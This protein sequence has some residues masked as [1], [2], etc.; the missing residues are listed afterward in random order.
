MDKETFNRLSNRH[1]EEFLRQEKIITE[2]SKGLDHVIFVVSTGVFV[3]SINYLTGLKDNVLEYSYILIWSWIFLAGAI[4]VHVL[5]YRLAIKYGEKIQEKL[6]KWGNNG[7]T[8]LDYIPYKDKDAQKLYG[9][10]NMLN[11]MALC[12][13]ILGVIFLLFFASVNFLTNNKI[14]RASEGQKE[15]LEST[16]IN[17]YYYG[18]EVGK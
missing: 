16:I 2:N 1:K 4:I 13:T 18:P 8:P 5:G 7:L 15:K 6:D 11:D 10:V 14:N 12:L 17:N 3:L 9:L